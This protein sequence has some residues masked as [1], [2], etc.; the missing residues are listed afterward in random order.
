MH[1]HII[2][3]STILSTQNRAF[4]SNPTTISR[5]LGSA[6]S[7]SCSKKRTTGSFALHDHH[8]SK[9]SNKFD[10][11]MFSEWLFLLYTFRSGHLAT[12]FTWRFWH[13][14]VKCIVLQILTGCLLDHIRAWTKPSP[15]KA[16]A[17]FRT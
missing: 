14:I 12:L 10:I 11:N 13:T 5:Q 15:V 4:Q 3:F 7:V 1:L 9:K 6:A 17:L 2:F 16:I 8:W